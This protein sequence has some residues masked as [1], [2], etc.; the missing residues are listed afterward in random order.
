MNTLHEEKC[1]SNA[2]Y[3]IQALHKRDNLMNKL[4]QF[5]KEKSLL[6]ATYVMQALQERE[7]A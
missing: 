2:A 3:V 6:S 4:H 5:M 1:H 7:A